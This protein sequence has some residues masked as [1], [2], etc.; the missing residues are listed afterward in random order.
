MKRPFFLLVVFAMLLTACEAEEE[1][2]EI[3]IEDETETV[4]IDEAESLYEVLDTHYDVRVAEHDYG[5]MLEALEDLEALE[6]SYIAIEKNDEPLEESIDTAAVEDEDRFFFELI[7]YDET[8]EKIHDALSLYYEGHNPGPA[9][10]VEVQLGLLHAGRIEA[11]AEHVEAFEEASIAHRIMLKSANGESFEGLIETLAD[12]L[13]FEHAYTASYNAMALMQGA[14]T[15]DEVDAFMDWAL[16]QDF[17]EM[18]LDSLSV[19]YLAFERYEGEMEIEDEK[20]SLLETLEGNIYDH[21]FEDNAASFA[22]AVLA[23]NA[24]SEDPD[25]EAYIEDGK[26]LLQHLISY[27]EEDGAFLYTHD[28]DEADMMFTT[29]QAFL[30]LVMSEQR[31]QGET[32]HPYYFE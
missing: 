21:P 18:G 1:I 31:L 25:G 6:G 17:D 19:M 2:A 26:T 7:W 3:T 14:E 5:L 23:L 8:A 24:A 4:R 11:D 30:A 28:D 15:D 10:A 13:E 16:E 9:D 20:R 12:E 27:Q 29:P 22:Q 32:A